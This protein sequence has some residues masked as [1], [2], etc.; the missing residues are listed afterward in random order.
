[1]TLTATMIQ[2]ALADIRATVPGA[3]VAIVY[4]DQSCSGLRAMTMHTGAPDEFGER[5]LTT[6]TVRVSA[7]DL[8]LTGSADVGQPI[9]VAGEDMLITGARLDTAGATWIVD[10]V[11]VDAVGDN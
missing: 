10:Y 4:G 3:S 6:N 7:A 8:T 1:M 5:G 2:D 11:A 9:T